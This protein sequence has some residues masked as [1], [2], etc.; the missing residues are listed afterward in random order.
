MTYNVHSCI[1]K[2]GKASPSSI[3]EIIAR[4]NPDVVALQE[5]DMGLIRSGLIDQAQMIAKDLKMDFHFHPSLRLEKGQYGN[6]ILSRYPMTLIHAGELPSL[7]KRHDLEK[8]GVLWVE[9]VCDNNKIHVFNTHL[10]LN[11]KERSA[12]IDILLGQK[13]L[14]HPRCQAP[15]IFCGDFNAL[16]LSK[17][18]RRLRTF[19]QDTQHHLNSRRPKKTWPSWFPI[20]RLDYIFVSNDIKATNIFAPRTPLTN[21]ASDHLPLIAELLILPSRNKTDDIKTRT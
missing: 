5:L 17:V 2:N 15:I 11:R 10:S 20:V 12:Q 9:V 13:W 3:A 1:G 19:L 21:N 14:K 18:Y 6:A 8:R 7:S 16:P 4:Y